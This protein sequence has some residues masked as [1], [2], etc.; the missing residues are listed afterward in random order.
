M[1]VR[2]KGGS[3]MVIFQEMNDFQKWYSIFWKTKYYKN[4]QICYNSAKPK[5]NKILL[6]KRGT[7]SVQT[8][9]RQG[10]KTNSEILVA[11]DI[12]NIESLKEARGEWDIPEFI[13]Y[14]VVA[15]GLVEIYEIERE[16]LLSHLYV[17]PRKYHQFFER[18]I[19]QLINVS[20]SYAISNKKPQD[21]IAWTLFRIAEKVGKKNKKD[22]NL[23]VLPSFVTQT[24][25]SEMSNTGKSRATEA[26]RALL[27]TGVLIQNRNYKMID[28]KRLV[29][30]L[31]QEVLVDY[32]ASET[33]KRAGESFFKKG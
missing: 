21:K 24:F 5:N 11:G 16:F 32:S 25:V 31:E 13:Q 15:L 10:E 17:D 14:Q 4:N 19:I 28:F 7:L 9:N 22:Q 6:I 18:T 33:T 3:W 20:F 27:E 26:Y 8:T 29:N 30:Y 23:I 2:E 12:V 1:I